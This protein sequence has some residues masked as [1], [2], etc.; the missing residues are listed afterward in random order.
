MLI[1][2]LNVRI[3]IKKKNIVRRKEYICRKLWFGLLEVEGWAF[4]ERQKDLDKISERWI[5]N[6]VVAEYRM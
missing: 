1:I 4:N 6:D 5:S 3:N 2:L